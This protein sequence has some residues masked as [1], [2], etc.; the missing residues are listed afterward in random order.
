MPRCRARPEKGRSAGRGGGGGLQ[1]IFFSEFF[2]RHI[3]YGVGV[4][5][6]YTRPTSWVKSKKKSRKKGGGGPRPI[7]SHPPPPDP[8]LNFS[9]I[10]SRRSYGRVFYVKVHV[11]VKIF[12]DISVLSSNTE[13]ILSTTF[14]SILLIMYLFVYNYSYSASEASRVLSIHPLLR[15]LI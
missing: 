10:V 2:L 11:T 15:F 3:H 14:W 4:P 5:S 13:L 1:H 6:A 9:K 12:E 8:P 7:Q